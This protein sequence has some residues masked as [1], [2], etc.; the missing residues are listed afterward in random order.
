[1]QC[2]LQDINL[3]INFQI[4]TIYINSLTFAFNL[5]TIYSHSI[6]AFFSF[7][8]DIYLITIHPGWLPYLKEGNDFRHDGF[9]LTI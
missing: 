2:L 5:K 9:D 6:E 8:A 1:M 3:S 4:E 7:S